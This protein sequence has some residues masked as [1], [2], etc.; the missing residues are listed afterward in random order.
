MHDDRKGTQRERLIDGMLEAAAREGYAGASIA[1]VIKRAGVSRPTFYD[2]F[3]DKDDCFQAALSE[4]TDRLLDEA[5]R[6]VRR[7]SGEH[8]LR[9][10]L[11]VL[12]TFVHAEPETARVLINDSMAGGPRALDIRD[13]SVTQLVQIVEEAEAGL[14]AE[15]VTPDISPAAALGGIYRML[16]PRLRRGQSE[17]LTL[18]E[19]LLAWIES[20]AERR[21]A[22]RWRALEPTPLPATSVPNPPPIRFPAKS[23]P[24]A[25]RRRRDAKGESDRLRILDAV[26]NIAEKK[27]YN[28]ATIAEICKTAGVDSRVFYRH[29]TDKQRAFAAA[30]ELY[31]Q[32]TMAVS[33][34]AFIS[35]G[36][37]PERIWNSA[38]V[39]AQ[40]LEENR[41]LAHVVFVETHAGGAETVKRVEDGLMA[42]TLFLQEGHE[43]ARERE[44]AVPPRTAL[45]AI[46][47]ASFEMGYRE[48]RSSANPRLTEY[49]AQ[50]TWLSLAPF[51][52]VAEANEFI[53]GKV[54]EARRDA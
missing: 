18:L 39:S 26:A 30:N 33:A 38:R 24:A 44:I 28:A 42:F 51:L 46:A 8:A 47:L 16:A 10:T 5:R 12:L 13:H 15:T 37:W 40:Y 54:S 2:Y 7:V 4:L 41:N 21:G 31:Y 35:G 36:S 1:H 29:F 50:V 27:G 20:Y 6:E 52:G 32:Q 14:G 23:P 34:S 53:A 48:L 11:Q 49:V 17:N 19:D 25:P 9:A 43:Y 45:E 22:Q 3:S